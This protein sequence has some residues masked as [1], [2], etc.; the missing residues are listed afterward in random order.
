MAQGASLDYEA[1]R[2][3]SVTVSVA[4][5]LDALGNLDAAPDHF[6]RLT[7]LITDVDESGLAILS[8]VN[9]GDKTYRRGETIEPFAIEVTGGEATVS[10]TGLPAGLSY[11][12][13]AVSGT[14]SD[15]APTG[16]YDVTITAVGVNDEATETFEVTITV[17]DAGVVLPGGRHRRRRS[18]LH[19]AHRP[20]V[21]DDARRLGAHPDGAAHAASRRT[22]PIAGRDAAESG[23]APIPLGAAPQ[24]RRYAL[25][26][27][28]AL[29]R[30]SRALVRHSRESGNLASIQAGWGRATHL[31]QTS[32]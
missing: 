11:G 29:V 30:H 27:S 14:V 13:G 21:G 10:L 9:P 12:G 5:G 6:A 2:S 15:E 18:R 32:P 3:Y 24:S 8:I 4:D 26:H 7:I 19:L 22:A 25:R 31:G 16:A 28:R 23:A 17:T 20:D 1:V